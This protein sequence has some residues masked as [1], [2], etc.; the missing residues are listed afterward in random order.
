MRIDPIYRSGGGRCI[1]RRRP[2]LATVLLCLTLAGRVSAQPEVIATTEPSAPK[3]PQAALE[4]LPV[5]SPR[6][7]AETARIV[8]PLSTNDGVIEIT[9]GQ[10]RVLSFKN[11]LKNLATVGV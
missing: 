8:E 1:D 9:L 6:P 4:P 11:E 10:S 2:V 5:K 3:K 7:A